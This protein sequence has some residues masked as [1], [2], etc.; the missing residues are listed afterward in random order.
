MGV[1]YKRAR[2]HVLFSFVSSKTSN[3]QT[4]FRSTLR[5][6]IIDNGQNA[7]LRVAEIHEAIQKLEDDY[8]GRVQTSN[9]TS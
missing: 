9:G 2:R 6:L 8:L 7:G 5:I 3:W 1:K 4:D